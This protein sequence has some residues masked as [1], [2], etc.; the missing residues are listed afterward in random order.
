MF[1]KTKL[2]KRLLVFALSA[3]MTGAVLGGS[4]LVKTSAETSEPLNTAELITVSDDAVVRTAAKYVLENDVGEYPQGTEVGQ[5][6]LYVEAPRNDNASDNPYTVDINGVFTGSFGMKMHFPGEEYWDTYKKAVFTVTS[7]KDPTVSFTVNLE[8]KY[9]QFG[10]VNYMYNG[11]ML[12]RTQNSYKDNNTYYYAE[13]LCK[14]ANNSQFGPFMGHYDDSNVG[15][16]EGYLGLEMQEDG[17]FDVV[18]YSTHN[19]LS[20]EVIASFC[21]DPETFVPS[22]EESGESPNLPKLDLSGGY[23][24]SLSIADNNANGSLDFLV[25][26]FAESEY[27]DPYAEEN[28]IVYSMDT[29]SLEQVPGFYEEYLSVPIIQIEGEEELEAIQGGQEFTVPAGSWMSRGQPEPQVVDKVQY[30]INGGEFKDAGE[31]LRF[32][33]FGDLVTLRYIVTP[34]DVSYMKE[35]TLQVLEKSEN[36][37]TEKLVAATGADVQ[38]GT[39]Y[40]LNG[41]NV[42][43]SGLLFTPQD[44]NQSYT[45]DLIGAFYGSAAL[46]W[47]SPGSDWSVGGL[48]TF[49]IAEVGN[50]ENSFQVIWGGQWQNWAYV[51]YNYPG[52]DGVEAELLQR[53]AN[54]SDKNLF[55]YG[56]NAN[57]DGIRNNT[58]TQYKPFTGAYG[59]E[60]SRAPGLLSLEWREDGSLD[61]VVISGKMDTRWVLASFDENPDTFVPSK[62][63]SGTTSNLPKLSFENG[64]TISVEVGGD[65]NF[66]LYDVAEQ[67]VP[68]SND[69]IG[70]M[71]NGI[72]TSLAEKTFDWEPY[73]YIQGK[74]IPAISIGD[75]ESFDCIQKGTEIVLPVASWTSVVQSEAQVVTDIEYQIAGGERIPVSGGKFTPETAGEY[76]IYYTVSALNMDFVEKISFTVCDYELSQIIQKPTCWQE[77][78]AEYVCKE[79]GTIKWVTLPAA[80]S[81]E[82]TEAKEAT[83]TEAGNIEY[84]TCSECG[85]YFSDAEGET[86][87]TLEDTVIAAKGHALTKT[88]AKEATCTE[89]GNIEYWTCSECGKYFSDEAGTEEIT[90]EETVLAAK[91]HTFENGVCIVCGEKDP[92]YQEDSSSSNNSSNDSNSST[93]VQTGCGSSVAAGFTAAA[94]L[95][96]AAIAVMIAAKKKEDRK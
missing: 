36:F 3:T 47:H 54:Q 15:W 86:E 59:D 48:V 52:R 72:V 8:R 76:T 96:A 4:L 73:F 79:C 10:Y 37:G 53:A 71:N 51:Q 11:E 13:N 93:V 83:C 94:V 29:E 7:V 77:G 57:G 20:R 28:G 34:R 30:S 64:Y 67:K 40:N 63:F 17:A 21:E 5:A 41:E 44:K 6:G 50:P 24:V 65:L 1:V 81:L 60:A 31:T 70:P 27:G 84:W 82:K 88:E 35:I 19:M 91:G 26:S 12:W 66:M 62:E 78:Y 49:T 43:R 2:R 74:Q 85:K 92:D 38:A 58:Q 87:I 23:T 9:Q 80:H 16:K 39:Q 25:D 18:L 69:S 89:A 33:T 56:R 22:E 75:Y 68:Y 45:I 55:Y 61:V 32:D 95:S 42:G 46:Q 14:D 90:E